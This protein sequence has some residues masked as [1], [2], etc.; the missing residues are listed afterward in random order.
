MVHSVLWFSFVSAPGRYVPHLIRPQAIYVK[1][2]V[3]SFSVSGCFN[4]P[5]FRSHYDNTRLQY[6]ANFNGIINDSIKL[7][8]SSYFR[9]KHRPWVHLG[10]IEAVQTIIHNPLFKKKSEKINAPVSTNFGI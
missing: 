8:S 10:L 2:H 1:G 4:P 9:Q 3:R 7:I 6:A 5:S